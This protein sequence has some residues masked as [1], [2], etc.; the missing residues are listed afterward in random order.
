MESNAV[1]LNKRITSRAINSAYNYNISFIVDPVKG[2]TTSGNWVS[3]MLDNSLSSNGWVAKNDKE[4]GFLITSAGSIQIWERGIQKKT[5][6]TPK[7]STY[8]VNIDITGRNYVVKINDSIRCSGALTYSIPVSVYAYVGAAISGSQVSTFDEFSIKTATTSTKK[9]KNFGFYFS[10][11]DPFSDGT[12]AGTDMVK[13]FTNIY[14][15]EDTGAFSAYEENKG[16]QAYETC[17][18]KKCLVSISKDTTMTVLKN[19]LN[20]N[21]YE[22]VRYKDLYE[23][24][25][26]QDEPIINKM[27]STELMNHARGV[28]NLGMKTMVVFSWLGVTGGTRVEKINDIPTSVTYQPVDGNLVEPY[29][30]YVGF[31]QYDHRTSPTTSTSSYSVTMSAQESLLTTLISRFPKSRFPTIN[32]VLVPPAT[33]CLGTY[34]VNNDTD[35]AKVQWGYY[36]LALSKGVNSILEF[37]PW[38]PWWAEDENGE[39]VRKEYCDNNNPYHIDVN[40][41]SMNPTAYK[42]MKLVGD[43]V[44]KDGL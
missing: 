40:N 20:S 9:L 33:A 11:G 2:N 28:R 10:E 12:T 18:P 36:N 39:Y 29:I 8:K 26:L 34:S 14:H 6:S 16:K 32:Y 22:S 35:L 1:R 5:C 42:V 3:F 30:D 24:V 4:F 27:S 37:T 15:L 7:A 31:D 17:Y 38:T 13:D 43:A 21:A 23:A 19:H 25:Y 44:T 41:P